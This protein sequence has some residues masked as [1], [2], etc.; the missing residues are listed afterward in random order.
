MRNIKLT[1]EY[2]GTDYAGWQRQSLHQGIT[3]QQQLEKALSTVFREK[4]TVNGAGRTDSGVHALGQVANFYCHKPVPV[5]RVAMAVNHQL[6]EDIR[7]VE[8]C[9]VPISFH[10]R[11]TSHTKR[12]RYLLEQQTQPSA[13]SHRYSWQIEEKLDMEAMRQ[14]AVFLLGEHDFGNYT[15]SG[16]SAENFVRN[17]SDLQIYEPAQSENFFPWQRLQQPIAI[18]VAANGFLYKMVRLIVCRL[19]SVGRHDLPS[20]AIK[21]FLDGSFKHN[22]RMAPPQGL[23]MVRVDYAD[24][25]IIG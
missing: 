20:V 14:G 16:V 23:M 25:D 2:D 22:I 11:F 18:E 24:G 8:A 4:I 9:E 3:V 15:V 21:G 10:S 5:T 1:V 19:V 6:P 17:I 12:Y 7:V 13:F